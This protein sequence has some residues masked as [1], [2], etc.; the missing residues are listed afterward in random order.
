[1]KRGTLKQSNGIQQIKRIRRESEHL[2]VFVRTPLFSFQD[3][4]RCLYFLL[5]A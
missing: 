4:T 5:Q 3:G 1:M 2:F